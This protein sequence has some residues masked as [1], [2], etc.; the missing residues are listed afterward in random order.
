MNEIL[1]KAKVEFNSSFDIISKAGRK[2]NIREYDQADYQRILEITRW[3]NQKRKLTWTE[4]FQSLILTVFRGIGTLVYA[5]D[6][7]NVI[8]GIHIG[9][10][11][12]ESGIKV[13][14]SIMTLGTIG[15][16]VDG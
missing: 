10:R 3:E 9:H 11:E 8:K 16:T 2:V 12:V 13:G 4:N 15:F 5:D 1:S 7:E 14:G 6:R